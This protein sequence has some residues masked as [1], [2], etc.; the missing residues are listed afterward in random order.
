MKVSEQKERGKRI[1]MK[2]IEF[3]IPQYMLSHKLRLNYCQI[4][5]ILNGK[6]KA[7]RNIFKS[8]GKAIEELA[9]E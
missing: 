5:K 4:N 8:M 3:G 7:R 2:L 1:K 9:K 6:I